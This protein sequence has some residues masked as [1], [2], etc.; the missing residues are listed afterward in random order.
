MN[1]RIV[2]NLCILGIG[3]A[4]FRPVRVIFNKG[5]QATYLSIGNQAKSD[6]SIKIIDFESPKKELIPGVKK[7]LVSDLSVEIGLPMEIEELLQK[8]YHFLL[9]AGLGGYTGTKFSIS[10]VRKLIVSEKDFTCIVSYP[11]RFEGK[12]RAQNADLFVNEFA[13]HPF[14]KIVRLNDLS[15]RRDLLLKQAFEFADIS[16]VKIANDEL[17]L[18]LQIEFPREIIPSRESKLRMKRLIEMR[19][20]LLKSS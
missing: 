5:I 4:G 14:V 9:F 13:T 8:D 18:G 3:D 16:L 2:T 17:N 1:S 12:R 6:D 11:F 15:K 19:K 20:E 10:I 7:Y